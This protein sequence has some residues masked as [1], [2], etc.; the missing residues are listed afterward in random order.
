MS[1][2]GVQRVFRFRALVGGA[3]AFAVILAVTV[4]ATAQRRDP[5]GGSG[6]PAAEPVQP[7]DGDELVQLDF[8]DVEL[9]VVIDTIAKLTGKNFIYDDRVRGRVTIISPS[10]MSVDQAYA[11]FESVLKVKGFTA[12]AGPADVLKIIPIRDAKESSIETVNEDGRYSP[13]R[14]Q[15]VTRLIPLLYI[16]A[17]AITTTIKPLVSKDASMVA[18]QPTNTIILTDTQSNI[19]RLLGI[20]EAIDVETHKEELAVIK[21]E[22]AD[23]GTLADQISEIYG[24][25]VTGRGGSTAAARRARATRRTGG[26]QAA[27][28][29]AASSASRGQVRIITDERTNSLLVLTSKSQL[30]DIRELVRKLD[31]PIQGGGRI[32]VYNLLHADAEEMAQTLNGLLSGQTRAP[33]ARSGRAGGNQAGG[34]APA[35]IRS[36][37]TELAQGVT[38][39]ADPATNSLV[40]QASK[41]AY[42]TLVRVIQELDISRPQV[43]VEALIMEF[44]VTDNESLGIEWALRIVNGDT[45]MLYGFGEAASAGAVAGATGGAGGPIAAGVASVVGR[46]I[47]TDSDGNATGDGTSYA[48]IIR[49]T[50]SNGNVNI[51]SAPHILTSDNEEAEIRIGNNIPIITSRVQAASGNPNLS[52]SVNV[53]RQDIGVTLRVTPQISEGDSLRLKIFQEITDVNTE[54]SQEVSGGVEGGEAAV[55]VSLTNRRIENTVVVADGET[56]VVGGL[57]SDVL[58]KSVNKVPFLGDIPVIGWAF[59]SRTHT[60]RKINLVVMLTP[61]IVRNEEDLESE[62]IRKRIEFQEDALGDP[63]FED[64]PRTEGEK[65]LLP[66]ETRLWDLRD[67]YPRARMN[68]IDEE[69]AAAREALEAARMGPPPDARYS[70]RV[71]RYG[72]ETAATDRLTEILDAGYDATLVTGETMGVVVFDIHVGEFTSL[73]EAEKLAEAIRLT[74]GLKP[75]VVIL[76]V[77]PEDGGSGVGGPSGLE[78][79]P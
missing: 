56:V 15:F 29:P 54:L 78:E 58:N 47:P 12:V 79:A 18:Y 31:I 65:K 22:H 1:I 75:E 74:F 50:A 34:G 19:R 55:G 25:E 43:L 40:I 5:R 57:I 71:A 13:N 33:A 6:R 30:S 72:D 49:A 53:E 60:L 64:A 11:V 59:K 17:E 32:H 62:S 69:R 70:L 61:H 66:V 8:D 9:T 21:V 14:D 48:A 20:L 27:A 23:A 4:P 76:P 7:A 37:I 67:R 2:S 16:D 10:M 3:I 63:S 28:T 52:T 41:E 45:Q 39:T 26:N 36:A 24:A 68:E 35:A 51:V 73:A 42:E 44:D 38:L 77:G 46:G